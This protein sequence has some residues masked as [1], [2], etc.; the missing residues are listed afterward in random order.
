M[1]SL[2]NLAQLV[3]EERAML[4]RNWGWFVALGVVLTVMGIAGLVFVGALTLVAV[5][6]VGWMFLVGGV[7][8]IAHAIIRKGWQ[9]FWLD[10]ISGVLTT[11]AGLFILLRPVEGATILT[12]L[13]GILFLVGGIFRIG[14][15]VATRNPYS[16]WFVLQGVVSLILGLM[17]VAQWPFSALW[18]IGTLVAIDLLL[19]GLRLVSFGLEVKKFAP[20]GSEEERRPSP[21]TAPSA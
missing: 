19:S 4:R 12:M 21:A 18:V 8:E 1:N 9:G 6:F 5:I 17:I 15:G 2:F 13:L 3:A 14:V 11:L 16:G 7:L 10:L 20:I